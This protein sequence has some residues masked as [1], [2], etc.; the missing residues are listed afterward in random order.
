MMIISS[1]VDW[2]GVARGIVPASDERIGL[3]GDYCL[4]ATTDLEAGHVVSVYR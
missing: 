1:L 4:M 3:R 2:Q